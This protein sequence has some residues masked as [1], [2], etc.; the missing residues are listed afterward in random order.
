[1]RDL[2]SWRWRRAEDDE[3]DRELEV[4][5]A[6]ELEEQLEKGIP[7]REAKLAAHREF[8]SVALTKDLV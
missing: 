4:H 2:R 8:G 7:L 1:M 3:V 5:L 6:P